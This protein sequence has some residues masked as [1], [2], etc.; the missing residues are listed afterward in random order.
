MLLTE[1]ELNRIQFIHEWNDF[2]GEVH[3]LTDPLRMA[4]A[5]LSSATKAGATFSILQNF[6]SRENGANGK[7]TFFSRLLTGVKTGISI[8]TAFRSS[9]R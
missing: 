7:K 3:R 2:K 5:F 8:W 1:S 6:F 4:G 9:R